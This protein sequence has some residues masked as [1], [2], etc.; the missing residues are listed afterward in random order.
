MDEKRGGLL[1]RFSRMKNGLPQYCSYLRENQLMDYDDQMVYAYNMLLKI[2]WLLEYFQ[3]QYP[4][5]CV[6]E[7]Q[8]TS[9]IQHAIIALLASRTGNLFMVGDEDQ[10]IYGFRAAY[11]EALLEFEQH[12]P[13]AK[14]LLMEDNIRSDANIVQAA[15][16]FIQNNTLRHEKHM[17]PSRPK[18]R[19][20]REISVANRKAQY[21]YLFKVAAS[22][23]NQAAVLYRDHECALPLIDLLERNGIPYRMR[24]VDIT[25]FTNRVV[26]D[27]SNIIKLAADPQNTELFLQVYYKLG[28][29]LRKQDAHKIADISRKQKLS[30]WEAAL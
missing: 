30:V 13:G 15:N 9:K 18:Q 10:S 17:H 3:N 5:I 16:R 19:E 11:P 29:Y 26:M 21:S 25:F 12:H 4:Y 7:A 24:N 1:F 20:I 28:T 22:C 8:D 6:D 27:I 23:T 14:V 2:P